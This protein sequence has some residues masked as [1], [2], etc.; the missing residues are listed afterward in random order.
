M[1]EITELYVKPE[2]RKR[3]IASALIGFAEDY[4]RKNVP[5]RKIEILTGETN[6]VAQ[7]AYE[8][9]GYREDG[10]KHLVKRFR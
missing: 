9:M 1:P 2:Y 4:C 10:E 5:F 6:T 7:T 8:R 3:G